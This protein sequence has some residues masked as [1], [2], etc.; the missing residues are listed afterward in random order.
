MDERELQ[1]IDLLESRLSRCERSQRRW[2]WGAS[3]LGLA[4]VLLVSSGASARQDQK[5]PYVE[6]LR[7]G[8]LEVVGGNE[9][10]LV[11][12]G[13]DPSGHGEVLISNAAGTISS[14]V[15]STR[16]GRGAVGVLAAKDTPVGVL[17]ASP[18]GDG[19][20][21]TSTADGGQVQYVGADLRDNGRIP[22]RAKPGRRL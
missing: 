14:Y 7:V 19:G 16:D 20:V 12:I 3:A 6:H 10:V 2:R 4:L 17:A 8:L 13:P 9:V 11:R 22:E 15:G 21:W 1:T 18:D 5:A